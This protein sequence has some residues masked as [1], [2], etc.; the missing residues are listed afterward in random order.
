M[1]I[2]ENLFGVLII[3]YSDGYKRRWFIGLTFVKQHGLDI[4][5]T[6][7]I[8]SFCDIGEY[9][10]SFFCTFIYLNSSKSCSMVTSI[11]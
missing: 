7:D 6:Y 3:F 11:F 4:D 5:L 9:Q 8:Q 1:K 2:D 10:F